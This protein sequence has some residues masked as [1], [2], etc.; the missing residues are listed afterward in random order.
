MFVVSDAPTSGFALGAVRFVDL[1]KFM[2]P[3]YPHN[4]LLQDSLSPKTAV[5]TA[6]PFPHQ[7]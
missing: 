6:P 2:M 1:Y 4:S 7:T 5:P 3:M